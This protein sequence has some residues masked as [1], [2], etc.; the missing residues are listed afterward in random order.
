MSGDVVN[1]SH[2]SQVNVMLKAWNLHHQLT[3][4]ISGNWNAAQCFDYYAGAAFAVKVQLRMGLTLQVIQ[5]FLVQLKR[6]CD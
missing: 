5:V 1:P 4:P 2:G 3:Y 6:A